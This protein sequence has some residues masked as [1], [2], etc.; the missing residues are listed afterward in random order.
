V[1]TLLLWDI[2]G[3]LITAHGAGEAALR[4]SLHTSFGLSSDLSHIEMAGQTDRS[5]FRQILRAFALPETPSNITLLEKHYLGALPAQIAQRGVSPFPG[6]EKIVTEASRRDDIV[7]G[8][9]TGNLRHGAQLKLNPTG[10]W[11]FLPF[12]AFGDDSEKRDQLGPFALRRAKEHHGIDFSP[13][14]VWVIGD[15]PYDVACGKAVGVKTFA[16]ATG[17]HSLACLREA[18]ADAVARDLSD[19]PAFWRIVLAL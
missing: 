5:I 1:K 6:I 15:T 11:S 14:R 9:L 17:R 2:D 4:E 12:G 3:T 16:L 19:V 7:Q 10:Y 8:L 18:G 13:E